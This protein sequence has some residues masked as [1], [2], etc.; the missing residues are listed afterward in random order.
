MA[1]R[2]PAPAAFLILVLTAAFASISSAVRPV[3]DAH[4]SAASELFAPSADGSFGDLESTYEA[5]RTFQILGLDRYKSVTGKACEFAAEKLASPASSSAKDL[6]HAVRI[7]GV[8]GCSV[9]AGVYDVV[10]ARLKAVIKDTNSLLEFY[11]SVGGL[12]S[13]KEQGHNIV[14][15]DAE[16]TFHA[17][18]ALS[19]SDGRWRYDTNSAESSTFAAG[20][21][22]EALAGVVSLADAEV[23]PSMIGVVKSD[24]VKLFDTIKSYD[25]GTFYF[26]EKPVDATEYK[27]PVM[28]SASVVRGVTAFTAVASGKLNIP[29][30]KILGL[31]KF[32]LGIGLP[33]S[34]KD[35]FNQIESLSFLENNRVFVPLILSLP[36][37]VFSL[38]SKDQ[39]KVEVTT[40]FGSAAPPLKVNLVQ[41]LGSDSKVIT[42]DNKELQFDRDNNVHYLDIAPLKIDV[43]KYSLVFEISLQEPDH[44]TVYATG[45][46]NTENVFITGLIKVDKAE[47]GISDNDA[48]ATESVQKLDL[49]KDTKVS[50]SANHL[51]KLRLSFQLTTPLGHTF[52]PHQVFLKLK[53]ESKVEHLFVVPGSARQFKLVLDFLGLVEKFYYLSGR[54]ELEFAVGDAAME[55][56]FLRPLGHLELDLPEAPEKAPRPPAQA[57]DPFSKFGPKAEISHIF[58]SPEKRPPK[59]LSLAFTGLTLLP[60]IGFLIGLMHLGVNMKNFPSLPGPAAFASLFHAGIGAVLLLYVLFWLKLD[61]FTTLKYLGFLSVFLVFVGHRTLSYLSSASTKQK[62]A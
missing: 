46:K 48:G 59:E 60:F 36:S 17:I 23:D 9:D 33:G 52:K 45:G 55:N 22:L 44:E 56:S 27:G 42:S 31:A 28:T 30:E 57:V 16:S 6:F 32:F 49:S 47:I 12:L 25:D 15:S 4:R 43:G 38:T 18:K 37:K 62:T 21:A 61:L 3:S 11:Y 1:G 24:I 5:V 26:D 20:I 54:Y 58:R 51:Q 7:S 35:C 29:G 40:V 10:V 14:L 39:L 19:Q 8:L 13:I 53:H 34:A 2:R 41:V 50:L